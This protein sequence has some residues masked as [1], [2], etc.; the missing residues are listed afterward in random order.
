MGHRLFPLAV[1]V[2]RQAFQPT[3]CLSTPSNLGIVR[4]AIGKHGERNFQAQSAIDPE[5][6]IP[7]EYNLIV[8]DF[9]IHRYGLESNKLEG[10]PA[11][12]DSFLEPGCLITPFLVISELEARGDG[13][14]RLEPK[15]TRDTF[16]PPESQSTPRGGRT[17]RR[18]IRRET[19][20][21]HIQPESVIQPVPDKMNKLHILVCDHR[22]ATRTAQSR[23]VV[24]EVQHIAS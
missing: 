15:I 4:P 20:E 16:E 8:P 7:A 12:L 2:K 5:P 17:S 23:C 10:I 9:T 6:H 24:K 13:P 3:K 22:I 1:H 21:R 18:R 11:A 14:A 19:R